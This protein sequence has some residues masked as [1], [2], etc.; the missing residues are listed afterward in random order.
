MSSYPP[1]AGLL[2][3]GPPM[4]LVD[5]IVGEIEGGLVCRAIIGDDF[6][7]LRD[8][9]AE[10]VVCVELVAQSV[11]CFTGL[12]DRRR[13]AEPRPGLLV[14][15]RDARF[16]GEPLR[17]GDELVITVVTRWVREPVACFHGTVERSG[18]TIADVEVTVVATNDITAAM[19]AMNAR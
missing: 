18:A 7:F 14:G 15:C 8:G 1:V 16:T 13:H 6:P 10:L 11:G 12:E 5:S 3:H 9:E 4:R 17:A 19:E 2:P